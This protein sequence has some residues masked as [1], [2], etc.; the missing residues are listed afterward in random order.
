MVKS[1]GLRLGLNLRGFAEH[2]LDSVTQTE[3]TLFYFMLIFLSLFIENERM[4]LKMMC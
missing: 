1:N 4:D 2:E 3:S